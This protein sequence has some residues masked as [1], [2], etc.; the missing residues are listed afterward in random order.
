MRENR[1]LILTVVVLA[2]GA[3]IWFWERHQPTTE[4]AQKQAELV[5]PGLEKADVVR[6]T[7]VKG[8]KR[9]EL[10]KE[11]GEW[12]LEK[13]VAYPADGQAVDLLLSALKSLK[14]ERRLD[15]G[16]V[17][18]ADWGLEKPEFTVTLAGSGGRTW[19]L[20]VGQEEPLGNN[21]AVTLDGTA[22]LLCP[23]WFVSDLDKDLDGWRSHEVVKLF[24]DQLASLEVSTPD[25]RVKVVRDGGLWK[26]LEPVRDLADR[27]QIRNLVSALNGLRVKAFVDDEHPDLAALGLDHPRYRV[28]LVRTEGKAPVTLEFG[29]K[30]ELE[31]VKQVVCRRNGTEILWVTDGAETPLGKAP[32]LWR[33]KVVYPFDTW[34]VERMTLA[35]GDARTELVHA[36][37]SWTCSGHEA[38]SS[39]V[40]DRLSRLA[41]LEAENFDLVEPGTTEIGSIT[42]TIKPGLAAEE[43]TGK[44]VEVTWT[45]F[46]PMKPGGRALVRVTGRDTIMSVDAAKARGLL[47]DLDGLCAPP[48]TPTPVAAKQPEPAGETAS[49]G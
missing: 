14:I 15:A 3:F 25:D 48:A 35:A 17:S 44:P 13:P 26:L 10:V 39:A 36:D 47:A 22:V 23:K 49:D 6:I 4:E 1:L 31:G 46:E 40:F 28:E 32:I 24:E 42:L 33:S 12:R 19:T 30:R 37:G 27:D 41:R 45:F 2:L 18:L 8:T 5:L 16:E 34:D 38:D 9:F 43:K 11:D 29:A 7:I 21:R 20:K